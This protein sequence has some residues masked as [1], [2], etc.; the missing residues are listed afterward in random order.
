MGE[1]KIDL[2]NMLKVDVT[3]LFHDIIDI[4]FKATLFAI[5]LCYGCIPLDI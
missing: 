1:I 4:T 2:I 3:Y 5:S